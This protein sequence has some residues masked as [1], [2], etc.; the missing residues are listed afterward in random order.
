MPA[1]QRGV[2][3]NL[4]ESKHTIS[5]SEVVFFFS[6]EFTLNKFMMGYLEFR[7]N[8]KKRKSRL[9]D[10]PLNFDTLADIEFYRRTEKRGFYVWIKGVSVDWDDLH[11]YSLRKMTEKESPK[12]VKIDRPKLNDRLNMGVKHI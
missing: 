8:L 9:V 10:T 5:N 12:W 1:T 2:Y 4:R 11:L 7:Q 6:S 3:H